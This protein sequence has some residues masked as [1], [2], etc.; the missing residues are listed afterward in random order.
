M[1]RIIRKFLLGIA[2]FIMINN[3]FNKSPLSV[4]GEEAT[5]E[6][7]TEAEENVTPEENM[8]PEENVTELDLGTYQTKMKVGEMQLLTVT[9]I[10][11][12][13]AEYAYTF[14]S[15][16]TGVATINGLGRIMAQKPGITTIIVTCGNITQSFTLT[17]EEEKKEEVIH[18]T[19]LEIGNHE[20]ELLVGKTL[21]L[22]AVVVPA[23]AHNGQVIYRSSDNS[24][25]TVT[26]TGEV[27]G[28][29]KGNVIIY[30]TAEYVTKEIPL[31]I[32]ADTTKIE[33][34]SNYVVLRPGNSFSLTANVKPIEAEQKV[35]YQSSKSEIATVSPEGVVVAKAY[36]STS[37]VVSNGDASVVASIIVNENEEEETEAQSA[38]ETVDQEKS[39]VYPL[40]INTEEV[41]VITEDMLKYIYEQKKVMEISGMGYLLKIDGNNIRNY[42]NE[43]NTKIVFQQEAEGISFILNEGKGL[44]GEIELL[45]RDYTGKYLYLYNETKERY[46][47]I[48]TENIS[49]LRLTTAGKYLITEKRL[50]V[51]EWN[52]DMVVGMG[53]GVVI[54]AVIYVLMKKRYWFW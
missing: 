16:D 22:S 38:E 33:L 25:A 48:E 54:L 3:D 40:K 21:T 6:A 20:S 11:Q 9:A 27:K 49:E 30:C 17:V 37:I 42:A 24:I 2:L 39:I 36:G 19:D 29:S 13:T 14:S 18:V 5:M 41:P 26:S 7:G 51:F 46:E 12:G 10:P 15:T 34:N 28:V 35:S 50:P 8:A 45:L 31:T 47:M 43:M 1:K 44:C 53:I 32:K 52:K 4:Y 23:N